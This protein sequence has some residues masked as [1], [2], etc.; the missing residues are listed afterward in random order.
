MV[1]LSG[2]TVCPVTQGGMLDLRLA[3]LYQSESPNSWQKLRT[4]NCFAR[5]AKI[6]FPLVKASE[7]V[8][9]QQVQLTDSNLEIS[10]EKKSRS[11][12][13]SSKAEK[14]CF[15]RSPC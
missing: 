3:Y 10:H 11:W 14:A 6:Y 12:R 1:D 4:E 13:C 8:R 5:A 2:Y 15:Q 7:K 9:V